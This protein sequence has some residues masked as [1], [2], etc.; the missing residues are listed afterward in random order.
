[1]ED[2]GKSGKGECN[3]GERVEQKDLMD[4]KRKRKNATSKMLEGV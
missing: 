4:R 1:L 2:A 3:A